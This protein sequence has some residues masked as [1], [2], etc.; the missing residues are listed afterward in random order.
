M[1]FLNRWSAKRLH[2]CYVAVAVALTACGTSFVYRTLLGPEVLHHITEAREELYWM[3]EQ[4]ELAMERLEGESARYSLGESSKEALHQRFDTVKSKLN[5]MNSRSEA[6]QTLLVLPQY[7]DMMTEVSDFVHASEVHIFAPTPEDMRALR[8]GIKEL[9]PD[10]IAMTAKAHE[11]EED[12]RDQRNRELTANRRVLL[13]ALLAGWTALL[14][15]GWLL[16]SRL[17]R[18][19]LTLAR[20]YDQLQREREA[21]EAILK[22]EE[23][24]NTF[25]GKVSHEINSPL[26]SIL[27]NVQL[28]ERRTGNDDSLKRIVSRL[29]I[30]VSHLRMQ[31]NDLLDVS[32]VKSGVMKLHIVPT[33]ITKIVRD[34]V[35]AHQTSAENKGLNLTFQADGLGYAH[36]DGRRL[37][38]ILTNLVS[39]GVRYT[40][41]GSIRVEVNRFDVPSGPLRLKFVVR[42]TGQG[43]ASDVLNNLY[44]PFMQAVK[45]RGGTGLGLAIV[46]GLVDAMNGEIALDTARGAGSTFTV[47]LPATPAT[48]EE[49]EAYAA[50][51]RP[52]D[53]LSELTLPEEDANALSRARPYILLVEDDADILETVGEFLEEKGFRVQTANSRNDALHLLHA[54]VYSAILLD[55]ELGDGSGLDVAQAA[56]KTINLHTPLICCTAYPDLLKAAGTEIFDARLSKPVDA[57]RIVG[58]IDQV[59]A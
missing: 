6:A 22:T 45:H 39:N 44:Q 31:V 13:G 46:K 51:A 32:E 19:A 17:H 2:G 7:R 47:T 11:Y 5:V 36:V 52:S 50:S 34:T 40:E 58:V 20:N 55:M 25:L 3:P 54:R 42:D 16:L 8:E 9:R 57:A 14:V 49:Y 59:R 12:Q 30:S 21:R 26:Q 48:R 37:G 23:A 53:V 27:T 28:M 15:S 33:D 1:K 4:L 56:K 38:Q 18:Q 24:R 41:R 29:Q 43:F 10:L 35:M